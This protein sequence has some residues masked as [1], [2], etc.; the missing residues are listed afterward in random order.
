MEGAL[1]LNSFQTAYYIDFDEKENKNLKK[2]DHNKIIAR[3]SV[4]RT[5]PFK[6]CEDSVLEKLCLQVSQ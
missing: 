5:I 2:L 3:I 1:G 6:R 4:L